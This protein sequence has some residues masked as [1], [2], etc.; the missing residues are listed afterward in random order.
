MLSEN[1]NELNV[2]GTQGIILLKL[3]KTLPIPSESHFYQPLHLLRVLRALSGGL[4]PLNCCERLP[5][6]TYSESSLYPAAI[7]S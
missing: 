6:W 7:Q 5:L 2:T 4:S 3:N 1:N